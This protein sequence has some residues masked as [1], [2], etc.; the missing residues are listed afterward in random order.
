[1]IR[2]YYTDSYK[3]GRVVT[4]SDT[5]LIDGKPQASTPQS[6]WKEYN[7]YI[8]T[9]GSVVTT[10]DNDASTN[11]ALTLRAPN[12][13][14]KIGMFVAGAGVPNDCKITNIVVTLG[15]MVITVDK[16]LGIAADILLTYSF[17]EENSIRVRTINNDTVTFYNPIQGEILP[18]SVVQVFTTGTNN[19]SGLVALS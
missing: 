1:M 5:L 11:S 19:I 18:V 7:L 13:N 10:N 16:T 15:T 8:G 9:T 3:E 17:P 6:V 4:A 2:N 12:R 14:I